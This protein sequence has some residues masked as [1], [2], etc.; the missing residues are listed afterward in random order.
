MYAVPNMCTRRV[1]RHNQLYMRAPS[2]RVKGHRRTWVM[3]TTTTCKKGIRVMGHRRTWVM[4]TTTTCKKEL[5]LWDIEGL[6]LWAPKNMQKGIRVMGHRRT[7]VMRTSIMNKGTRVMGQRR[8]WVMSTQEHA[9][10]IREVGNFS[11][12][13]RMWYN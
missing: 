1:T 12:G 11:E 5:G 10:R 7:W 4:R 6:E 9:K 8:K 2:L 3:R 13:S